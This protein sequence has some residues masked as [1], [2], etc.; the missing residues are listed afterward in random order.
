VAK[1]YYSY[2]KVVWEVGKSGHK[3]KMELKWSHITALK[4]TCSENGDGVLDLVVSSWD[5]A[6]I[7]LCTSILLSMLTRLFFLKLSQ[8]PLFFKEIDHQQS[9]RTR[10]QASHDFTGG[11]ASKDM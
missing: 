9:K 4:A 7:F 1:F 2:N 5:F 3:S 11:Q 8:P 6:T 10:W